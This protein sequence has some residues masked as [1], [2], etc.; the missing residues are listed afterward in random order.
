[1]L[2]ASEKNLQL[3]IKSICRFETSSSAMCYTLF[4][5]SQNQAV[6]D[7]ARD[8]VK[9]VL[10]KNDGLFTYEALIEMTYVENCISGKFVK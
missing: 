1:M 3:K 4:E 9:K 5:L 2:A 6:Q 8:N 10:A 7:K